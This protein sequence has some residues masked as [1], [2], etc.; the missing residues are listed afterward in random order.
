MNSSESLYLNIG[1]EFI[2][3]YLIPDLFV[4][5]SALSILL[6]FCF[7]FFMFPWCLF[8]SISSTK[9]Y[10]AF[11]PT[12][13]FSPTSSYFQLYKYNQTYTLYIIRIN[14]T[15]FWPCLISINDYLYNIFFFLLSSVIIFALLCNFVDNNIFRPICLG[16]LCGHHQCHGLLLWA[17]WLIFWLSGINSWNFGWLL[18]SWMETFSYPV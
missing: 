10:F 1:V 9:P 12:M 17:L 8:N 15:K 11:P 3:L 7:L 16:S 4:L 14:N 13:F 6:L 2:Y 5:I 18:S